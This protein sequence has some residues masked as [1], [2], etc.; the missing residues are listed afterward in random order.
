MRGYVAAVASCCSE[1]EVAALCEGDEE[2]AGPAGAEDEEVEFLHYEAGEVG[3]SSQGRSMVYCS[4]V[5]KIKQSLLPNR[6]D[7]VVVGKASDDVLRRR[8]AQW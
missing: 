8:H 1:R 7:L 6:N 5:R 3:Q 4:P 2:G